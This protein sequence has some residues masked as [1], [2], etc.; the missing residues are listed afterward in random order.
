MKTS[1]EHL[2]PARQR[3]L[4]R[5]RDILFEEFESALSGATSEKKKRGRILKIIL[6]GSFARGGWV[7]DRK[8]GYKSDYDILVI[9]SAKFLA[10]FQYW[11]A[12]EDRLLFDPAI[13][14]EV[15]L[16]IEPLERVNDELA[17]GQ[18]FFPDIKKDGIALY[19]LKGHELADPKPLNEAQYLEIAAEYF[20]ERWPDAEQFLK[21]AGLSPSRKERAARK[22]DVFLLHQAAEAA[23]QTMLLVHT[24]YSPA[25][26]NIK[27]L[28]GLAEDLDKRLIEVWPRYHRADKRK[29]ELL[30]RAYVEARYSKH[31][32]ITI[33]ELE[34]LEARIRVLQDTV[35][36]ICK[37]RLT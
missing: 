21:R 18:Y 8:S 3:E 9:V 20:G 14:H 13:K 29:F 24:L 11:D 6:F 19:E 22:L 30:R 12:A 4:E 5:I 26:H 23:Y 36:V 28:R 31:Y 2:P 37:E 17:K 32:E 1:L 16:I 7:N 25:T 35:E 33:D 10:D 27:T 34:W 15:Q